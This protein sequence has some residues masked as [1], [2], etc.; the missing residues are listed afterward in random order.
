MRYP[1][2]TG[3][4]AHIQQDMTALPV[5]QGHIRRQGD[6]GVAFLAFGSMVTL[7]MAAA[8]ALNATVADMRFVKP[9]DEA[10]VRQ[11]AASHRLL[12]TVEEK[13]H[14]GRRRQRGGAGS[15]GRRRAG[16]PCLTLGLPDSYVEHGDPALLLAECGLDAA[17]LE[18]SVRARLTDSEA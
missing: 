10:L 12:V 11:L 8:E 4:G 15:A 16:H 13:R 1:R 9:L 3:P 6:G 17:G 14:P 5:G 18:A 7:A 2:G